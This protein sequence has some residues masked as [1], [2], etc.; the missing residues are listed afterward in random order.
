M[1]ILGYGWSSAMP[2]AQI[3]RPQPSNSLDYR[4][5]AS[6]TSALLHHGQ[7]VQE[8]GTSGEGWPQNKLFQLL[9]AAGHSLGIWGQLAQ[10]G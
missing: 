1:K 4:G 8:R 7:D 3:A 5:T 6:A 9:T 10:A 2:R